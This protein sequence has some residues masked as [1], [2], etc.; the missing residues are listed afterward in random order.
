MEKVKIEYRTLI[1]IADIMKNNMKVDKFNLCINYT[2][3]K[4]SKLRSAMMD[5]LKNRKRPIDHLF[6]IFPI[7]ANA[8][9]DLQNLETMLQ[10]RQFNI[11]QLTIIEQKTSR[12]EGWIQNEMPVWRGLLID[13]VYDGINE[14]CRI[15]WKALKDS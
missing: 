13:N 2:D 12:V 3:I 1:G 4:F 5:D 9:T 8:F 11:N 14:V 10:E 7:S 15:E 6:L